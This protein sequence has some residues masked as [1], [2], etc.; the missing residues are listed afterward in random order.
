MCI[1]QSLRASPASSGHLCEAIAQLRR[2]LANTLKIRPRIGVLAALAVLVAGCGKSDLVRVARPAHPRYVCWLLQPIRFGPV[3]HPLPPN[4]RCRYRFDANRLL[5]L[6]V[7]DAE[8]LA[9]ANH[10]EIRVLARW[11]TADLKS[12]RIN[13]EA[14]S[15]T[16]SGVVTKIVGEG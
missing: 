15:P 8:R 4:P 7:A 1:Q 16:G 12:N 9:R 10:Y 2:N 14:T 11:N 6:S 5:G 13:V 3:R